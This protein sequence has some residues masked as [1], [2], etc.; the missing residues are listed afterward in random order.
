[1]MKE[2]KE[3][4]RE[5][6]KTLALEAS[7]QFFISIK[8][9]PLRAFADLRNV[10]KNPAMCGG[11]KKENIEIHILFPQSKSKALLVIDRLSY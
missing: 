9:V 4:R 10:R 5:K 6:R 11:G 2:K 1:M 7:F 8:K 3:S